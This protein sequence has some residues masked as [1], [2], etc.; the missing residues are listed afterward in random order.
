LAVTAA[1]AQSVS[2]DGSSASLD[3]AEPPPG[4]RHY[5]KLHRIAEST[6]QCLTIFQLSTL[7]NSTRI[8]AEQNQDKLRTT[9]R[10]LW[11]I[12]RSHPHVFRDHAVDN[13]KEEGHQ[14]H[15]AAASGYIRAIATTLVLIN[16][17]SSMPQDLTSTT[18]RTLGPLLMDV[19]RA[20]LDEV[21]F[22]LKTFSR[23]GRAILAFATN[24]FA[25]YLTLSLAVS[26]WNAIAKAAQGSNIGVVAET[27]EELAIAKKNVEEAF[28][29]YALLPDAASMLQ[30]SSPD[31]KNDWTTSQ[32]MQGNTLK[33]DWC[34]NIG[35]SDHI[36]DLVNRVNE[37]V[38]QWC[39]PNMAEQKES[40][41][42]TGMQKNSVS[43]LVCIQRF[44]PSLARLAY[45]VSIK[46]KT[47]F[48]AVNIGLYINSSRI[49]F[50]LSFSMQSRYTHLL[51]QH[52]NR[53]ARLSDYKNAKKALYVSLTA[54]DRCLAE[55]RCRCT[56][57]IIPLTAHNSS[58]PTPMHIQEQ[59]MLVV[60]KESLYVLAYVCQATGKA[61]EAQKCLV[62]IEHYIE[63][64]CRRDDEL[65]NETMEYISS[66]DEL[67][68]ELSSAGF[69]SNSS[70]D[71][72]LV[73]T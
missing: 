57:S 18:T 14:Q 2:T 49:H 40:K 46:G 53:F 33:L 66:S 15:R 36:V 19:T 17:I 28:D 7:E 37:F 12:V 59:E 13:D 70:S 5:A 60:S 20:K 72:A 6:H 67:E 29:A 27:E 21:E 32:Y 62:K 64:Q 22:G 61:E 1:E 52:G 50:V 25:A 71:M 44:L 73:G 43:S 51:P 55:L 34:D 4:R 3:S 45:K 26:C 24:P 41:I 69:A 38:L 16:C 56:S 9:G 47:K 39:L 30:L 11:M 8:H 48:T 31:N 65:Y 23:A 58:S 10:K 63:E 54:T 68:C 42:N 35:S